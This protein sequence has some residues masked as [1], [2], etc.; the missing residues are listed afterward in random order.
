MASAALVHG[1]RLLIKQ[2]REDEEEPPPPPC[3]DDDDGGSGGAWPGLVVKREGGDDVD[4]DNGDGGGWARGHTENPEEGLRNFSSIEADAAAAPPRDAAPR[5]R[6]RPREKTIEAAVRRMAAG[7]YPGRHGGARRETRPSVVAVGPD[8]RCKREC[9]T[10]VDEDYR[11]EVCSH[12]WRELGRDGYDAQTAYLFGR[13][14]VQ[15]V[16]RR[17][18]KS[19]RDKRSCSV[20]YHVATPAGGGGGGGGGDVQV[21]KKAFASIYG[22]SRG[23]I[24]VLVSKK[25]KMVARGEA[26]AATAAAAAAAAAATAAT[27]AATSLPRDRRGLRKGRPRALA[28]ILRFRAA[29]EPA[30]NFKSQPREQRP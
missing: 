12:F 1:G 5:K 17:Y 3:D 25:K 30:A 28:E 6:R 20:A 24:D 26:A 10:K 9:F 27:A 29:A 18:S 16:K 22:I 19:A 8:C 23:R 4:G 21:C 7:A 15:D 13:I 14:L 11:R 2:E